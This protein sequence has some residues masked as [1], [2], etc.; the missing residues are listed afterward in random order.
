[1]NNRGRFQAQGGGLQKSTP[2]ATNN[3]VSKTD[4][5][6]M[7]DS[8]S[9]QLT[10]TELALR[11]NAI[12]KIKGFITNAPYGGCSA[13]IIKSY[14]DDLKNRSIRI[15]LEVRAGRAFITTNN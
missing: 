10:D 2:W 4:G 6:D 5:H 14:S 1:M 8:L 13:P 12:E 7:I 15:D 3:E 11:Q 9:A